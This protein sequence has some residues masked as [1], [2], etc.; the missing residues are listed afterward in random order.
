MYSKVNHQSSAKEAHGD[1]YEEEANVGPN[2]P[3]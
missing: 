2:K 1:V 3:H